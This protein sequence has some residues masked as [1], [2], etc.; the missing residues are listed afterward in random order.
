[1]SCLRI[2]PHITRDHQQIATMSTRY[3][4]LTISPN[5]FAVLTD[6]ETMPSS[7]SSSSIRSLD[8]AIT[9]GIT[10]PE[11]APA[12]FQFLELTPRVYPAPRT[13]TIAPTQ[14][15]H[16]AIDA[17]ITSDQDYDNDMLKSLAIE[18]L[19]KLRVI[20]YEIETLTAE[21]IAQDNEIKIL[22]N[23]VH[24]LRDELDLAERNMD[25]RGEEEEVLEKKLAIANRTSR[26]YLSLSRLQDRDYDQLK[27]EQ[28]ADREVMERL[29]R[30][31]AAERAQM[32]GLDTHMQL[33]SQQLRQQRRVLE[34]RTEHAERRMRELERQRAEDNALTLQLSE[35]SFDQQK[36]WEASSEELEDQNAKLKRRCEE[37]EKRLRDLDKPEH[38]SEGVKEVIERLK[39]KVE[40]TERSRQTDRRA[41]ISYVRIVEKLEYE[42]RAHSAN[43]LSKDEN[44][45][46]LKEEVQN[47]VKITRRKSEHNRQLAERMERARRM[48]DEATRRCV[49]EDMAALEEKDKKIDEL[50]KQ[51]KEAKGVHEDYQSYQRRLMDDLEGELGQAKEEIKHK[52]IIID[53]KEAQAVK[54]SENV[55]GTKFER[56]F[57]K[58]TRKLRLKK[59]CI[60]F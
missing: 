42:A 49:E 12:D 39:A 27:S 29:N 30:E 19:D 14:L 2:P 52:Q 16:N 9:T 47:Y 34:G 33:L 48:R 31:R 43:I 41:M 8:L 51:I 38:A 5:R 25:S 37:L 17:I 50:E 55:K 22:R 26:M 57:D 28:V 60:L 36:R 11:E 53:N 56:C 59:V 4:G 32:Q 54:E 44:I 20:T 58:V 23:N 40:S 15:T 21:K 10:T 45:E 13:I 1:M 3:G 7:D 46:Q 6:D 24:Y 35:L 18:C